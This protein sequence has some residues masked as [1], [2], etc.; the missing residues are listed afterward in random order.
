[1]GIQSSASNPYFFFVSAMILAVAPFGTLLLL[2]LESSFSLASLVAASLVAW[3]I[4]HFFSLIA[5]LVLPF[6]CPP[7]LNDDV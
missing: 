1:M 2:F 7:L 5:S 3:A 4:R 6:G